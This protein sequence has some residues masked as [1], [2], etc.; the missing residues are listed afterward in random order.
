VDEAN[1]E[2]HGMGYGEAS[3]A[4]NEAYLQ[5]HLERNRRMV[6][7]DFNHPSVVIWS[8]G[9]EGGDGV[10]F[11]KCYQWIKNY[12]PS[13]PVQYERAAGTD[14]SDI[15]CPMY[16]G[17]QGC[18]K[19]AQSNPKKPL[20]QCEYAHAMGN[21]MGGLKEY[22]DIVRAYPA[23]Q[24]GFIWDFVDQA[25][26]R[27]NADG[28]VTYMYGGSYNRYDASDST[29]N[30][31]GI[32][33]ARRNYHPHAYE[34]RYVYQSIHTTPV[35]LAK[36]TVEIYNENFFIGL[37]DCYLEWQLLCNGQVKKCGQ[38][39]NLDVAPQAK[40]VV[41][42]PLGDV[43]V[44]DGEVFLNVEYKRKEATALL[45][46]GHVE[47]Y[48]QLP[49][50]DYDVQAHFAIAEPDEKPALAGDF[51][52][53]FVT[54]KTWRLEFN[55]FT[56][57]LDRYV[58]NGRELLE[59]PLH[60][61]FNRAVTENGKG[62]KLHVKYAAWRYPAFTLKSIDEKAEANKVIITT[63][64]EMPSTGATIRMSYEINAAGEIK[65]TEAMTADKNRTVSDMFRFGMTFALPSRYNVVEFY[66]RGPFENYSDR[67][68]AAQVGHYRQSVDEQYHTEYVCPQESGTH[69]DLR[70][71]RVTDLSGRGVEILSDS[72]FSASALPYAIADLDRHTPFTVD[73][74]TD[75]KKRNATYVNFELRQMGLACIDSWGA[76]PIEKYRIPYNDYTFNFIIRPIGN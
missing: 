35:D 26:H 5:T 56:G 74:P 48:D 38:V 40:A 19:Y 76:L 12:D 68:A 43:S 64:H 61:E 17:Y 27:Y 1:L 73:Y 36:G 69:A 4:K 72:L 67:K 50:R 24:G 11:E 6:E 25:L 46:A 10:N 49:V 13:R 75:L 70:W 15:Y 29:F 31:N 54:G 18:I 20:I 51:N 47:A 32:I 34:V 62:A 53:I 41:Q 7:R 39:W 71:W 55:R 2:S 22:L 37:E 58:Y 44:Y 3:L 9:N 21:S 63:V 8:M 65:A 59:K 60:P 45:P 30:N 33:S 52:Y 57:W 14:H 42:L 66:G 28:S 16:L 23:Y